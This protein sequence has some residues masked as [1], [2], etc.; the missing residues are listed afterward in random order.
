MSILQA[1]F[2]CLITLVLLPPLAFTVC[3]WG[4]A[5]IYRAKDRHE[6]RKKQQQINDKI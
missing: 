3:K 5:G 4:A 2:L 1:I 6:L